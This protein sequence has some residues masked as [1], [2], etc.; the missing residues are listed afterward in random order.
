M[1][2]NKNIDKLLELA[3]EGSEE[4]IFSVG[5]YY[6]GKGDFSSLEKAAEWY[7][8]LADTGEFA[9]V[10]NSLKSNAKLV[11]VYMATTN[12]ERAYEVFET[13]RIR[14]E[15]TLEIY[16]KYG[17]D[18]DLETE[19][20]FALAMRQEYNYGLG[21]YHMTNKEWSKALR[22]LVDVQKT[23]AKVLRGVCKFQLQDAEGAMPDLLLIQEPEFLNASK[24]LLEE[25]L[26]QNA[27][28]ILALSYHLGLGGLRVD[29][30]KAIEILREA[31]SRIKTEIFRDYV[32]SELNKLEMETTTSSCNGTSSSGGGCYVATA[33]YGSYDCPEVWTLR[34]YRDDVLASTWYGRAFV[35]TYYAVSPTLVKWFGHTNWF[36]NMWRDKLDYVVEALKDKG[37]QDTPYDDRQW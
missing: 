7:D 19:K 6:E 31:K 13:I 2:E 20:N 32:A 29:H 30:N 14:V 1:I 21:L 23:M 27:A 28:I 3:N 5:K 18:H 15:Q 10:I 17:K 34:R 36:K 25:E 24:I 4:A 12:L 16:D 11:T 37:F 9:G 26:Y 8:K 33:V 35:R 22:F